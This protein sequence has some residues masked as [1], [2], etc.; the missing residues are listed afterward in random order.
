MNVRKETRKIQ[1]PN[2]R[3]TPLRDQWLR[4]YTP[5]VEHMKLQV[6]M[7][8]QTRHVEIRVSKLTSRECLESI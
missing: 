5:L 7:N 2:H 3:Y 1:V 4:L 6:R 8:P